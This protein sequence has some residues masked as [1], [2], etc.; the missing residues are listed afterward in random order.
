MGFCIEIDGHLIPGRSVL[1]GTAATGVKAAQRPGPA[2]ALDPGSPGEGGGK[3]TGS[4]GNPEPE[5]S[6]TR[7]VRSRTGRRLQLR[8]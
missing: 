6:L 4:M 8:A 3:V 7:R 5:T 2:E 1:L